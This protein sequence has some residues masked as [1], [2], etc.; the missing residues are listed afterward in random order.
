MTNEQTTENMRNMIRRRRDN[1]DLVISRVPINTKKAFM[2]I[3]NHEDF[4]SDWGLALKF[5]VDFY[6]GLIPTGIEH[7]ET[8]IIQIKEQLSSMQE[9]SKTRTTLSGKRI[10]G[11]E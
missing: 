6:T 1:A 5:L 7:L 11:K 9:E 3:A 8:E 10:G 4:C 2:E